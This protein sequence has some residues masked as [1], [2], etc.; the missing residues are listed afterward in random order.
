MDNLRS[1]PTFQGLIQ[2]ISDNSQ[3]LFRFRLETLELVRVRCLD[4]SDLFPSK[5][6]LQRL[7]HKR[8]RANKVPRSS[9][10][11]L[12]LRMHQSISRHTEHST[13][14]FCLSSFQ[15]PSWTRSK[16]VQCSSK[17]V[18]L[19]RV[20]RGPSPPLQSFIFVDSSWF[21][22]QVSRRLGCVHECRSHNCRDNQRNH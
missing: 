4:E 18:Q 21:F 3:F 22:S 14:P 11:Q 9:T 12:R 13:R 16:S 19:T 1:P 20:R 7:H 10:Y 17:L 8:R 6:R 5:S 15:N 2:K